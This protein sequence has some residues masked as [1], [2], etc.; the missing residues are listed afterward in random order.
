MESTL[1]NE[2]VT[3]PV[4]QQKAVDA[5]DAPTQDAPKTEP[6]QPE[7]RFISAL[8]KEKKRA[9]E[10]SKLLESERTARQQLEAR[11]KELE[12][13]Y[14]KPESPEEALSRYGF[15]YDDLVSFKMNDNRYTP[16]MEIKGLKGEIE[17][18]KKQILSE[19]EQFQKQQREMAEA[20][21]QQA[22]ADFKGEIQETV[23]ADTDKYEL[24]NLNLEPEEAADLIY[25]TIEAHFEKTKRVMQ[26]SEAAELVE[27][28]LEERALKLANTKK[29]AAKFAPQAKA[30]AKGTPSSSK[31]L[32][33]AVSS[34]APS[35]IPSKVEDDRMARALA[36]LSQ[37]S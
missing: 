1:P 12:A 37:S 16:E 9:L 20:Q 8:A 19:K 24:I 30:D 4:D 11:L 10:A 3:Q 6:A 13:K 33:N 36:A 14:A 7:S 27:K 35:M 5:P 26:V 23:K 18:F 29:L 32:S 2:T 17:N 21:K 15:T 25:S 34:S 31:T 22:I 28:H